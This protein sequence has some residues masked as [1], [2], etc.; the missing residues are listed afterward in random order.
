MKNKLVRAA[1]LGIALSL[2]GVGSALAQDPLKV[3]VLAT[4][5]GT[6]T[7]LGED[8]MPWLPGRAQQV[9]RHGGGT[10]DRSDSSAP[11]TRAPTPRFVR[12]ARSWSRTASIS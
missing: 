10:R 1:G 8:G 5:E 6:Y 9:R 3:G 7:V 2:G 12:R 11:P 4:L